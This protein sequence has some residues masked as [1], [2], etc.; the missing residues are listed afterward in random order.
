MIWKYRLGWVYTISGLP[1]QDATLFV[2]DGQIVAIEEGGQSS[3]AIDLREWAVMPALVNAHTHLEFSNLEGP[4]GTQGISFPK[5]ITEVIRYRQGFGENIAV[6]KAEAVRSGL[7]QSAQHGVG[8]VGEIATLPLIETAYENPQVYVVSLL[9]VL[10]LDPKISVERLAQ[11][12]EHAIYPWS[13][14]NISPGISPHAPYSIR[15]DMVEHCVSLSAAQQLP[16]A[17]HLAETLE[18]L[19]LLEEGAGPF[20]TMLEN[21]GLFNQTDFPGGKRVL[22][23]LKQLSQA[24]RAMVVHGNYLHETEIAFLAEHAETMS[25]CYCPRT[26]AYFH[27]DRHLIE[28]LLAQGVSVVLGTDSR[29]SNPDLNLWREVQFVQREFPDIPEEQLLGM[30]TKDA[31]FALGVEDSFGTIEPGRS[32]MVAAFPIPKG[33]PDVLTEMLAGQPRLWNLA[34]GLSEVD[35][36][37][38]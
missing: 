21:M 20:R 12:E 30:V 23:Y 31:A 27:H 24:Y 17:M 28:D 9:E 35:L 4:L 15:M 33:C 11:A 16:L 5:W 26:H 8:V 7:R 6:E 18:E 1:L 10:G 2:E 22:A 3:E 13:L 37:T 25:V 29:A 32:A 14:K 19:Q 34:G 36:A 38:A